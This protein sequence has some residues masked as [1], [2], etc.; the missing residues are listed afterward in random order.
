MILG[1]TNTP[2]ICTI[3]DKLGYPTYLDS[4][5]RSLQILDFTHISTSKD[6]IKQNVKTSGFNRQ[7]HGRRLC[8]RQIDE[9]EEYKDLTRQT[10][11]FSRKIRG[12]YLEGVQPFK[13]PRKTGFGGLA[14]PTQ[15]GLEF[16]GKHFKHH[17]A[18]L[19]SHNG[20]TSTCS[21][22]QFWEKNKLLDINHYKARI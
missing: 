8:H 3:L 11:D 6:F 9:H 2:I 19:W 13:Q 4:T 22:S 1:D 14:V 21:L 17:W 18:K 7:K 16:A 10:R 20:I 12:T 5:R 15:E